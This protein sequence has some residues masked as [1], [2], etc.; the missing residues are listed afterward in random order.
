MTNRLKN[1]L[2]LIERE[3]VKREPI[4]HEIVI[5][6]GLT[7][8][9]ARHATIGGEITIEAEA[10][11][12]FDH[13]RQRVRSRAQREGARLITFGGFPPNP[14]TWADPPGQDEALA[15]ARNGSGDEIDS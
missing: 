9:I 7:R 11:E 10:G 15:R 14:P 1:R 6:G 13:F 2:T 8:G 12:D 5:T 4:F 3:L